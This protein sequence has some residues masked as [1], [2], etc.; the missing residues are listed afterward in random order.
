VTSCCW[1]TNWSPG[2]VDASPITAAMIAR[3]DALLGPAYRLMHERPLDIV[4]REG[5][6]LIDP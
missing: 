6:W 5:A 1:R 4:R 3:R 2:R